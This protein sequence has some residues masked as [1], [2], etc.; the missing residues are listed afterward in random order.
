MILRNSNILLLSAVCVLCISSCDNSN[1]P[2]YQKSDNMNDTPRKAEYAIVIHG[3]AGTILKTNMT[4]E[5]EQ[6]YQKALDDALMIGKA[7]LEDGGSSEDAVVETIKYMENSPLFN[8]GRGAVFT[9]EGKNELDASIMRGSDLEAGAVGGLQTIKNPIT[10]ARA[11]MD[12][13]E[14]VFLVGEGAEAFAKLNGLE[15][16]DPGYFYTEN[17][18]KS[19]Q[20]IQEREKEV[21]M[22]ITD[23]ADSKYGTVGAVA[24]D[25]HGNICAGTS[26]GGMTNKSFGRIGDSPV[27]GAGTYANNNTCGVSCTGHGEFFIRYAVAYDVSAM[28]QYAGKSLEEAANEIVNKKLMDVGGSGG[29]IALDKYGNITMPFNSEG[30]YRGYVTDTEKFIGIYKED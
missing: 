18:Y 11:V 24:L 8:A 10:A 20:R 25:K 26:T 21:G 2:G 14:H 23:M 27:I 13:S 1:K 7:I 16:V 22:H 9:S 6:Q 5:R 4:E 28:M 12:S 3:G 15:Q 17:R 29:L 30:M 19:L